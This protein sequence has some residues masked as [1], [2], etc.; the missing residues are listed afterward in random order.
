MKKQNIYFGLV[1]IV[2]LF[3]WFIYSVNQPP[4]WVG[5]SAN[6]NWKTTYVVEN[7]LKGTWA[8]KIYWKGEDDANVS[9]VGLTKNGIEYHGADL[10]RI[11]KN[12]DYAYY[13][14]LGSAFGNRK[15]KYELTIHWEDK[16]GTHKETITM[17]PKIRFL[18]LPKG[19]GS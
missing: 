17:E 2:M 11:I 19:L 3:L 15:D 18:I 13:L 1:I 8:G 7:S 9:L 14:T 10:K 4:N 16:K 6:N 5:N 12:G